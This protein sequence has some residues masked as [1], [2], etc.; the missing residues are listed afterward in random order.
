MS[1]GV[2]IYLCSI[3]GITA[4]GPLL[5]TSG[6]PLPSLSWCSPLT[7]PCLLGPSI[8]A[9]PFVEQV[10]ELQLSRDD[11]EILK[12]I[13]RGAYG[14]VAVVRL[15]G[16]DRV[17][18][19]KILHKW[20]MLKR[21]EA[22]ARFYLAEMVLAIDSLHRLG[23]VH[24]D[25]K[26]DNV[27][28]D[29]QGHVRLADFGSC[30]RLGPDG[31]VGSAMAAGTPDYISPEALRVV[32]GGRG[33]YG[34]A[35]DWWAL[36]VCAYE[37]LFGETPFY[38]ESLV[39]TYGRIM[40][41]EEHLHFP[42]E[43]TD[44]SEEAKALIRGL[45]CREELRL[46]RGGLG[47]FQE[48][49]FFRGV[50]W[51]RLR[52]SPAPYVPPVAGPGDTSNFD[53]DDDTLKE[54]E[55]PPPSSQGTFPW[56]RLPFVGFTFMSG[57][58]LARQGPSPPPGSSSSKDPKRAPLPGT[59]RA[60]LC[61]AD[62]LSRSPTKDA[63]TRS[64]KRDVDKVS[65]Q[66][67]ETHE[68][69]ETSGQLRALEK[70]LEA[71]RKERDEALKAQHGPPGAPPEPL[72]ARAT[73]SHEGPA[74]EGMSQDDTA[75]TESKGFWVM[76]QGRAGAASQSH[77]GGPDWSLVG[78]AG[79]SEGP[80]PTPCFGVPSTSEG[81]ER[82]RGAAEQ[83]DGA[84]ETQQLRAQLEALSAAKGRLEQEL[85]VL[86]AQGEAQINDLLQWVSEEKESRGYL[87]ATATR[88]AQELES[89]KQVGTP[90]SVR[91]PGVRAPP[92]AG[93]SAG[94]PAPSAAHPTP[95]GP[96]PLPAPGRT[97]ASGLRPGVSPRQ[98]QELEAQNQALGQEL[99][100]L[101]AELRAR[102]L[103]GTKHLIRSR[104]TENDTISHGS[105][106]EAPE[107]PRAQEDAQLR[108]EGR[109]SL[110]AQTRPHSL[111]FC[112]VPLACGLIC[113]V[114]CAGGAL[115]C[116]PPPESPRQG[117]GAGAGTGTALE[118]VLS[119]P[120]PA[121]VRK[122]WQRVFAIVSDFRLFL[123]EAPEGRSSPGGVGATHVIDL[124][125]EQ[126][127]AEL[128]QASDVI[129]ANPKDLPCIFRVTALQLWVPR[130][131]CSLLLLAESA[132]E[133]R[134]WVQA[135]GA[136]PR[137]LPPQLRP[138]LALKE[139][140]DSGLP[141][142]PHALATAILDRERI[143]L[144]TEDGLFVL[145]L[146]T[147][148]VVQVG[149]CR[150]VQGLL[151]CPQAQVLAVL[152][153]RHHSVR[154][155]SWAELG[156]PAAPGAKM[157][158]VRGCQ[159]LAA[160]VLCRGTTPV[161]CLAS[162]RQV[163][164]VQLVPG[165]PPYRR[166][167]E[168]QAPGYV[169]CLD[170]LGDRLCVGFPGGFALYPL[171][172]E[173][174]PQPLPQPEEP[175][176]RGLGQQEALR[177]VEVSLGELILCFG[178]LGVYVDGRGRRTRDQDLMWPAPPLSCCYSAPYLTV[179]S[180]N[181]LDVFDVRKAEW[182]QTVPLRKVRALN[183]EGSLLLFGTEKTRLVYLRNQA[184][185]QD[186]IKI[187]EITDLSRRQLVRTSKRRFSFRISNEERQ[188]QRKEMMRD[189]DARARLI[190]SPTNFSHV[191]HV[192]PGDGRHRLQDLPTAQ[193]EKQQEAQLRPRSFSDPRQPLASR[194]ISDQTSLPRSVSSSQGSS[195]S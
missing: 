132:G 2:P 55:S 72:H 60:E 156:Q 155:F 149:D 106:L 119:V 128:V 66:L 172:N 142:L 135:L 188:Q 10:K 154:L 88:L 20:E 148:D 137:A 42:A 147:N 96:T 81:P 146:R 110:R 192:G 23:Y 138:V 8:P 71:T 186:E 150:R 123:F 16:S 175:R 35:C 1:E 40:A 112:G 7:D 157:T 29:A 103:E 33:R 32:E 49:P 184:A 129:H 100:K 183:P 174:A 89:L 77:Q 51:A 195:I 13:G 187:P 68:E 193:A 168:L 58:S 185:D 143:A 165:T 38:A 39:E 125:A 61:L 191:V 121:G 19:M 22:R 82:G 181:A 41:H 36:G 167:R 85:Q 6:L 24:R 126:F 91:D 75:G 136:L 163:L 118:G 133:A 65:Q 173:G 21:A 107:S 15:R 144:G 50:A 117:L 180:E 141:L 109:R 86:Q 84:A 28:L 130:T 111:H 161:L 162:K 87:Q 11:F 27:L 190:S 177:A 151:A 94:V 131:C 176:S 158:E 169:Q 67:V 160:G 139:A 59:D 9:T 18:A 45:L 189:P 54:P 102:T 194:R 99:E 12:V 70:Q 145:H 78:G 5:Y 105:S 74:C 171:L 124:R 164:C 80:A 3:K 153:G 179:F 64:P 90:A 52:D 25:I 17:Y 166:G 116:P 170:V 37:L 34:P 53:V 30:L 4:S 159:A 113:H 14:E 114:G 104:S 108:P 98:L 122:G 101:K 97:Q 43:V 26:P 134:R 83:G 120:R 92:G 48:H 76:A 79:P 182:V 47:D 31:M 140:Y 63:E 56:H 57:S 62:V 115:R 73:V 178:G 46:G 69:G 93:G 127:S 95:P 44:V 152:C